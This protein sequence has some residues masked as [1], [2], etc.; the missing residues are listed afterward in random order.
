MAKCKISKT[1]KIIDTIEPIEALKILKLLSENDR[2][3]M[4]PKK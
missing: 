3:I 4:D 2:T 1:Q